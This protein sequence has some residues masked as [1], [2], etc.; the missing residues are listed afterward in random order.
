VNCAET[1]KWIHAYLDGELD[2]TKCLEVETHLDECPNCK[3]I[4]DNLMLLRKGFQEPSLSYAM[5]ARVESGIAAALGFA[6]DVS[7]APARLRILA[8]LRWFAAGVATCAI[9]SFALLQSPLWHNGETT[10]DA[11]TTQEILD[12]H[13]RSLEVGHLEDVVST[14]KHTVKPWFNGK[15]SFSPPVNDLAADGFPLIGGRLD[16][17]GSQPAAVLVYHFKK[18]I[19]NVY[20]TMPSASLPQSLNVSAVTSHGYHIECWC[21]R[22]MAL[23][24][25]SDVN[26]QEL[27][28]FVAQ[29][30]AK[31][32]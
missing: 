19:I 14:D 11:V 2:L 25:V 28:R 12:S 29:F 23:T 22:D 24:A 7:P 18:H 4:H 9:A 6:A 1:Q 16:Y 17:L 21:D 26:V 8:G 31:D 30:R 3:T 5:P 13:L 20:V 10:T 15:I 32:K 27:T